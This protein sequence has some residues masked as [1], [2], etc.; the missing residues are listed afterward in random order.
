MA[1]AAREKVARSFSVGNMA[2]QY[3]ELYLSKGVKD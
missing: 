3:H 2:A 1:G